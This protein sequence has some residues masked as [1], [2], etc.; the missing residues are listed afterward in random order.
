MRSS[1]SPE[2]LSLDQDLPTTSD[3]VTALA[4]LRGAGSA[5][6]SVYL[7]FLASFPPPPLAVLRARRGPGGTPF[8]LTPGRQ[9][10]RSPDHLPKPDRRISK[11]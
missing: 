1:G 9:E 11:P 10:D 4:R 5:D 3:D 8:V 2:W 6:L 7:R